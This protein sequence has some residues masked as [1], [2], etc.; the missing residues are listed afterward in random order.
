MFWRN[1]QIALMA[2]AVLWLVH[3]LN[4]LLPTDLRVYGLRPRSIDGLWGIL[5]YPF[6]HGDLRHLTANSGALFV[7]LIASLS[8]SRKLTMAAILIITVVGGGL[9]WVFGGVQTVH[10]GASGIIYGLIGFLMFIAIF[11]HEW[12]ALLL[13]LVVFFLYGGALLSLL[14]YEPGISWTGHFFGFASGALAASWTKGKA[15]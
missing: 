6:L 8:F 9:V 10:I 7:L 13:S 12:R 3:F 14:R 1:V 4:F 15:P 2:V 5:F 11:R